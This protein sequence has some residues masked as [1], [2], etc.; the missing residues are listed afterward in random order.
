MSRS[1]PS[2]PLRPP[3]RAYEAVDRL[4][5]PQRITHLAIV[6]LAAVVGAVGNEV[7]ARYRIRVGRRIGSAALE[8]DGIHAR[9]DGVTSLLVLGV[10][11]RWPSGRSGPTPWW[12]W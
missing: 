1:S 2:S 12:V 9:T 11:L 6:A 7:V 4:V 10:P 3:S 5:H 8:A